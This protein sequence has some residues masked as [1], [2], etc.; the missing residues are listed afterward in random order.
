MEYASKGNLINLLNKKMYLEEREIRIIIAQVIE[1]LL[2]IHSKDIIYGDLKA[3]NI[4]IANNGTVKLCDFNLS[5]TASLLSNSLQ[6]TVCY[7]SPEIIEQKKKTPMSDFWSLG[8]LTHLLFYRKY[9]FKEASNNSNSIIKQ[10]LNRQILKEPRDRR[11]SKE[12]RILIEDLLTKDY[13]RRIGHRIEDF[14]QHPFF[15][16]FDW[17]NYFN[18]KKNFGYAKDFM[19]NEDSEVDNSQLIDELSI[20]EDE[21]SQHEVNGYKIGNFTYMDDEQSNCMANIY[22]YN[23][24]IVNVPILQVIQMNLISR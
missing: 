13:K 1:A 23:H 3:E 17:S 5:G 6:G 10:I 12:L 15:K 20:K 11:A 16:N 4:L 24:I 9:P 21:I 8:V 19:V 18:N 7:L 2:Y 14:K 22:I